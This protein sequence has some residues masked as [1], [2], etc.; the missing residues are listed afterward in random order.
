MA[1][2]ISAAIEKSWR[3]VASTQC[4]GSGTAE[5]SSNY[6]YR[7]FKKICFFLLQNE[8]LTFIARRKYAISKIVLFTMHLY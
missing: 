2:V 8:I 1:N 7:S 5:L 4:W 3:R 6:W